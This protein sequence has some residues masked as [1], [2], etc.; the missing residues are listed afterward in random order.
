MQNQ[1]KQ[2]IK[3]LAPPVLLRAYRWLKG[4]DITFSGPYSSWAEASKKATGYH[5]EVILQKV[6]EAALQV[7]SGNAAYE[8][9]S[10]VFHKTEYSYPVLAGLL[11]AAAANGGKLS[12][13]DFGGSLGSSYYQCRGFLRDLQELRWSII[14]QPN[15]RGLRP[16]VLRRRGA[17]F[18]L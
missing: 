16:G 12:V 9:D 15:F 1:F 11:A 10:V 2:L 7:K 14:E 3:D 5:S 6:K 17:S 8:R 13:L 4:Q 18:L